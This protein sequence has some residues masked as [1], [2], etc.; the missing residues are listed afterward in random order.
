MRPRHDEVCL[1]GDFPHLGGSRRGRSARSPGSGRSGTRK[2][3]EPRPV[4]AFG[5][6]RER[7]RGTV[8]NANMGGVLAV[9]SVNAGQTPQGWEWR[10][11]A[12]HRGL[13]VN[14][15]HRG[16]IAGIIA[17]DNAWTR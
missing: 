9:L 3:P 7:T 6:V 5:R 14:A 4:S 1:H 15:G 17:N 2:K 11:I 12:D 8:D 16:A 10:R 13:G